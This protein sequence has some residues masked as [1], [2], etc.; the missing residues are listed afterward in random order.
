MI[1]KLPQHFTKCVIFTRFSIV[2]HL[3][4]SQRSHLRPSPE[5]L[6]AQIR[7]LAFS[8]ETIVKHLVDKNEELVKQNA[9]I[10]EELKSSRELIQQLK[11]LY[12]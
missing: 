6:D 3:F 8:Q 10:M 12:I 2:C 9:A 11:V 4:L 5:R 1:L 7:S